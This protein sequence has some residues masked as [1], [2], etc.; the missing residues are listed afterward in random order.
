VAL[1]PVAGPAISRSLA[2]TK[3]LLRELFVKLV[4]QQAELVHIAS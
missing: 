1:T 4:P 2:E 3:P